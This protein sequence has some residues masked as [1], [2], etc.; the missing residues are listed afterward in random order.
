VGRPDAAG[1]ED[2][3]VAGAQRV[4]GVDDFG[5][6]IGHHARFAQ[7]DA[8]SVQLFRQ[9]GQVGVLGPAGQDLVADDEQCCGHVRL[10]SFLGHFLRS[11][12]FCGEPSAEMPVGRP[13][14]CPG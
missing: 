10:R 11:F 3:I 7:A 6:D 4:H 5:L 9:E 8:D 13:V 14:D 12:L 2:I 1:G